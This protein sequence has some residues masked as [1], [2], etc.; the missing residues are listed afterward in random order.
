MKTK[1]SFFSCVGA[2]LASTFL[3]AGLFGAESATAAASI[4]EAFTKGKV[5][6]NIRARYEGVEQTGLLDADAL[7]MRTRLGFTTAPLYGFKAMLEA[8][9]VTAID[10]DRYSQAGINPGGARRAVVADPDDT[11]V[12][13]AWLAYATGNTTFTGGRQRIV[14]DNVRFVGDVGWRQNA[15]TFDAVSLTDKSV[16]KLTLHYAY[17]YRINRVFSDRHPQGNWDSDSHLFNA[18]YALSPAATLTGYAYLLEF[19]NAVAN[20]SAT[21]GASVTGTPALNDMLK[22]S[23]RGE[24]AHQSDYRSNPVGYD[25]DYL[26][27]ELG[28][29][30]KQG[31]LSLGYEELGTDNGVGFKTPLATLHAFNGWADVFLTTPADGLRDTYVKAGANLPGAI[32]LLAFYHTFETDRGAD[33]GEEWDVQLSRKFGKYFTGLV[34]YADFQSDSAMADV[35]K[36]WIQVEF[37]F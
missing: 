15:Q 35:R 29:V 4:E 18:S 34:K 30:A 25:T 27:L 11:E 6:L 7:T 16:D 23:Y 17:L 32:S 21:Y 13:Q 14:Y 12:N 20:S 10:G 37:V 5:S 24:Y 26:A 22:L 1:R 3:G 9:D 33:L 36:I 19:E 8:E 2:T 28:V 31:S